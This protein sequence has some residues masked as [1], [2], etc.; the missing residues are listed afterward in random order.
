MR[1]PKKE[2]QMVMIGFRR[3]MEELGKG[4]SVNATWKRQS[5]RWSNDKDRFERTKERIANGDDRL[6]AADGGVGKGIFGECYMEKT[7]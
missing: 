5:K 2:L 7:E 3:L 1:E 4:F 6:S